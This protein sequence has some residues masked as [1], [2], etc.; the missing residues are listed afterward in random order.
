MPS[1]TTVPRP[2]RGASPLDPSLSVNEVLARWPAAV[3]PLNALGVDC[4]CGGGAS[5]REAAASAGVSLD[6]LLDALALHA[7]PAAARPA[8]RPAGRP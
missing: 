1:S 3:A 5:L 7:V 8:G 6:D 4:C 2:A